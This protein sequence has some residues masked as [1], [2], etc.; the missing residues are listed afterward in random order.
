MRFVKLAAAD[1]N[2]IPFAWQ[3]NKRNILNAIEEARGLG[4]SIL[5][6]PELSITGYGCDDDFFRPDLQKMSWKVLQE[7][8]PYTKGMVVTAGLP[9][10][11]KN[12]IYNCAAMVVDGKICGFVAK[13]TLANDGIHYE[14]RQFEAWPDDVVEQFEKEGNTYPLGDVYFRVDDLSIGF[15]ICEEAWKGKREGAELSVRAVDIIVNPS[16]S[17]FS[18]GKMN[19]RKRLVL[20]GSRAF[21]VTYVYVNMLGNEAGRVI[22]DGG[23][24]IAQGGK[25]IA[26]GRRF[27]YNDYLLT[28]GL[29]DVE[30][31]RMTQSRTASFKPEI[32]EKNWEAKDRHD[33]RCVHVNWFR[34][35]AI[36]PEL[37]PAVELES[38]E[39]SATAKEEEFARAISLGLF[40]YL[41]KSRSNGFMLS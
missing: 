26:Q 10:L 34:F 16:A 8:L 5:C 29:V 1:L 14:A 28:V 18:F 24:M 6:L 37:V 31:T 4:V 2:Q 7:I 22:Y 19:T 15:E 35:P 23:T 41:R 36:A 21:G 12:K 38:W 27:S 32:L 39:E 3:N 11:H 9:L 13:K 33:E 40:D 20:E 30:Y 17:H 25:M